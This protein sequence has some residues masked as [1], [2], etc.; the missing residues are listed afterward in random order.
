MTNP[1]LRR[2]L[3]YDT[4]PV[5]LFISPS[6]YIQG[7]AAINSLG[8]YLRPC[9]SGG[10]GVVITPGRQ[11]AFGD[12]VHLSL[13]SAGL[14]VRKTIFRGESSLR[15]VERITAFF[16]GQDTPINV[17]I[18]IGGGKCLDATRMAA[19]RLNVP[20]VTVPTTAS[21]DAPTAGHSVIYD[22]N[23][24]FAAL[25]FSARNP[26][27]VLAD[28]DIMADAPPRYLIAG[29][30]DAFSTFYEAR[31]C[32]ENPKA[33][34]ARGARPTM[35]A[36]AIARQCRDTLLDNG[37]A[38]LDE[39]KD[40]RAG[41]AFGRIVEAN[42]LMSGLGFESGGLAGAHGVAQGLTACDDLHRNCLHGELV[43]IGVMAQ[44][45]MEKRMD[46][47][48]QA[49]MFFKSVGLP[50][51]LGNIGF[52]ILRR[53]VDLDVIVQHSLNV[54]FIHYE[55]FEVTQPLLKKAIIEASEYG[56]AAEDE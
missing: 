30:G 33:C 32:M 47:A 19:S 20:A 6:Q 21:T 50:L 14:R 1:D 13:E 24:V 15:E 4:R 22:D 34:T 23:G 48:E 27:L 31:C 29:M 49:A 26:L 39:I 55:P 54:F 9:V 53:E 5:E 36:L 44:L 28:L 46:E 8:E 40:G 56:R 2:N 38:A 17:L 41:E 16:K 7:R 25:E 12:R 45:V 18:G 37:T 11:R 10:A 43:A 42:I 3:P 51:H 35:A 52:D